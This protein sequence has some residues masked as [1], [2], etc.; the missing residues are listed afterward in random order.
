MYALVFDF[1]GPVFDARSAA[2]NA[3]L[4]TLDH[5]SAKIGCPN[6]RFET[7]P[8]L[9]SL[10]MIR[11]VYSGMELESR[12]LTQIRTHYKAQLRTNEAAVRLHPEVARALRHAGDQSIPLGI[13]SSR[14][15]EAVRKLLAQLGV[16]HLFKVIIGS[17]EV[18]N[19]KPSG[20][21][22]VKIAEDLGVRVNHV[23]YVGDSDVDYLS[24]QVAGA[25]YLHAGWTGEPAHL[26]FSQSRVLSHPEHLL[27]LIDSLTTILPITAPTIPDALLPALHASEFTFYAG[28]GVSVPSGI[29]DWKGHY[30]PLVAKMRAAV[31]SQRQEFTQ[32]MQLLSVD[33]DTRKTLFDAFRDSFASAKRTPNAYHYSI[34]RSRVAHVWTS[35]YDNLFEQANTEC[36][37]GA[38]T[39]TNDDEL[40][41]HFASP[42]LVVKM[43]GGVTTARYKDDLDWDLILTQ[44]Q[45]DTVDLSR[46]EI[47]RSFEDDYRGTCI[48]FVGISFN[49]PALRRITTLART[50]I[51]RTK[52][53][54][55]FLTRVPED[56][57]LLKEAFL[58][59]K[60]L[61][62]L[63]IR[64][65]FF[66]D[67]SKI[68]Q[69]VGRLAVRTLKPKVGISGSAVV[70]QVRGGY[71]A[72][73]TLDGGSAP[74]S[75]METFCR[76]LGRRLG[77]GGYG[78][79]SCGAPFVGIPAVEAAFEVQP[80]GTGFVLRKGGDRNFPRVAPVEVVT[81]PEYG[82]MRARFVSQLNLLIAIG[83][84]VQKDSGVLAEI[85]LALERKVPVLLVPQ[86]G[87]VCAMHHRELMNRFTQVFGGGDLLRQIV[88]LNANI[89]SMSVEQ[90]MLY[91]ANECSA[92]IEQLLMSWA[93]SNVKN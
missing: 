16:R 12:V 36:A 33:E 41:E 46:T 38:H 84:R 37:F 73:V 91:V 81:S 66:S 32:T 28:A 63:H 64:A 71:D 44:E 3:L 65:L 86:F 58:Q 56:P 24:A 5:F 26:G 50:R 7:L 48:V 82:E 2:E 92:D 39:V 42:K 9:N 93:G 43:N 27:E 61:A 89:A 17:D 69:F 13:F 85:A 75:V 15:R 29:G 87:G 19:R 57:L 10:Q 47:W 60:N 49:D 22:L 70:I 35:N 6:F 72:T 45:F 4:R 11:L 77:S 8:L 68:L 14:K 31:L 79:K 30:G 21:A 1:D 52:Y 25:K 78:V 51:R 20:P 76:E 54:H 59:A 88:H 67:H 18:R 34:L 62:R 74:I 83:G 23:V 40:L 80:I 90:L 53:T 55:L